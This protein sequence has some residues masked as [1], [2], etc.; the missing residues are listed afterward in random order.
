MTIAACPQGCGGVFELSGDNFCPLCRRHWSAIQVPPDGTCFKW[1]GPTVHR[2]RC[3]KKANHVGGHDTHGYGCLDENGH[4]SC[5]ALKDADENILPMI[6]CA[7]DEG[8]TGL[9]SWEV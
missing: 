4:E 3:W 5:C 1:W 8:H 7:F 9:H 6:P 2:M